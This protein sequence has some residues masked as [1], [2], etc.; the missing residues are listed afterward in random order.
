MN[1]LLTLLVLAVVVVVVLV[2]YAAGRMDGEKDGRWKAP[3][4]LRT[5]D[6]LGG[7]GP[8]VV[9]RSPRPGSLGRAVLK[10]M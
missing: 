10:P 3:P 7:D 2:A 6:G 8:A 1:V 5:V 9:P 4:V